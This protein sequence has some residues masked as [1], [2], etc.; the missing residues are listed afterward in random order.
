MIL[1]KKDN[2]ISFLHVYHHSSIFIIWWIVMS[3][4]PGGQC[5]LCYSTTESS[6]ATTFKTHLFILSKDYVF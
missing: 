6:I 3:Y 2:Q 4:M 5:K 1:R